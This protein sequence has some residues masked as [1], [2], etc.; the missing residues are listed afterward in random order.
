[1]NVPP[2]GFDHRITDS[3]DLRSPDNDSV[4]HNLLRVGSSSVPFPGSGLPWGPLGPFWPHPRDEDVAAMWKAIK[5]S[6]E[7]LKYHLT[8]NATLPS[9]YVPPPQVCIRSGLGPTPG[10]SIWQS[11]RDE[12][13]KTSEDAIGPFHRPNNPMVPQGPASI[14]RASSPNDLTIESSVDRFPAISRRVTAPAAD[15]PSA[16]CKEKIRKARDE[17]AEGFANDWRGTPHLGPRKNPDGRL[18]DTNDCV[19]GIVEE[20]CRPQGNPVD[21]PPPPK[22]KRFNL[23]RRKKKKTGAYDM[24]TDEASV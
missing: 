7:N 21:R 8:P 9:D 2:T 3:N 10:Q 11:L 13:A 24:E 23:R 20:E 4:T 18:W 6:W 15:E 1:M 16:E 5:H 22:V 14:P 19:R 12:D 17:C